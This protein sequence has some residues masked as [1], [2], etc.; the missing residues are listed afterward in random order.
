M[1]AGNGAGGNGRKPRLELTWIGKDD[2]PRLEPRILLPQAELS[3]AKGKTGDGRNH[4]NI[5]I[6]GDNLLA[7]KA[8]EQDFAGKVKCVF[9][10]PP[11][12][13]GSAFEQY[14]DGLEHSLWLSLM[15][16]RIELLRRLLSDDGS[17]WISI[18]DN[19][20]HYLRCMMDEMFG[21][22]N[23]VANVVWQKNFSPKSSARHFSASHD[24]V[25]VYAKNIDSWQRNLQPRTATQDAR[26]K[27]PD[28]DARGPWIS[29][30]LTARNYYSKGTYSVRCPS[31]RV[32]DGPPVGRYWAISE[33]KFWE[34]DKDKRIWWG[35]QGANMPR[36]KR[37]LS[38]VQGGLVPQTIWAHEEVG[39]TQE[40]KKE[41]VHYAAT[42]DD[43]FA[44]P[45]P[46]RLLK[47]IVEIAT[48]PGDLVL[49]SFA[50]S[51]TTGA[52]AH[53]M[54]RRW[55]M[56][57]LG[58]HATTHIVPRLKKVIDGQDAGGVTAVSGWKGG[59]GFR[60]YTLAPSLIEEDQFGQKI[61]SKQ[62]R[63]EMLAEAMCKHMG[64]TYAPSQDST[65]YWQQGYGTERDFIFTTTQ[66]L[67]YDALKALSLEVG[68]DRHL[69]ICCK[70]FRARLSDFPNLTVKKIPQAVLDNCE[71]GRDDYSFSIAKQT[72]NSAADPNNG[73]DD[74][75]GG[76]G[77]E[78][79]PRRRGRP[80]DDADEPAAETQASPAKKAALKMDGT[81]RQPR[82]R[83]P[84]STPPI[85]AP[86]VAKPVAKA[87]KPKPEA[88]NGPTRRPAARAKAPAKVKAAKSG[89]ASKVKPPATAR[90]QREPD[91]IQWRLL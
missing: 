28:G 78:P 86:V 38:D 42:T 21:R 26:Y 79:A 31:G 83:K 84:A 41:T 5:L 68:P 70:A 2:R 66:S 27:N 55:I 25:L 76:S 77:G 22:M 14:D 69:L 37:F 90:T 44:T 53:K 36:L 67:A 51:G 56:I 33:E 40:A 60:Y 61:I 13:T 59:G 89:K 35:A 15:R 82:A 24:F 62:Y 11:Y 58:D 47:R 64:Y 23:F 32:I 30:Q 80:R 18:D 17:I 91:A 4:D 50:G 9:I 49:D 48:N 39:N 63:P 20:Q 7:L 43:V 65:L 8:L 34:L 3:Y 45:K 29:D 72:E 6:H 19:E 85:P 46:E 74:D 12:N 1:T 71:W 87:A 81:T 52:V 57:E 73:F 10:D 75:G 16:D 54:G 88:A